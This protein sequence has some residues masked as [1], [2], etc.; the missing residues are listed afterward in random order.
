[1][2]SYGRMGEGDLWPGL[3]P[4]TVPI[5]IYDGTDTWL[6]R[7]PSPPEG[8]RPVPEADDAAVSRGRHEAIRANTSTELGEATTAVMILE[9]KADEGVEA[10]AGLLIHEAFHVFQRLR[11]P[12]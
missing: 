11:H 4:G 10:L 3:D 5:A 8:F 2:A 7:H 1:M 9:G 12:S 6:F